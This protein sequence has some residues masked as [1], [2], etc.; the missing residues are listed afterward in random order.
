MKQYFANG[1]VHPMKGRTHTQA[2]RAKISGRITGRKLS[3]EHRRKLIA[4]L[5]GR[6]PSAATRQKLRDVKRGRN[7][8]W[9]GRTPPHAHKVW[10]NHPA[11][12]KVCV[13]STWEAAFADDLTKQGLIWHFEPQ[14]FAVNFMLNG[15]AHEGTY[16]PDFWV[17]ELGLWFEVKGR[18]LDES[19]AKF[20][21]FRAQY[22]S[23]AI[24]VVDRAYLRERGLLPTRNA[25]QRR[26]REGP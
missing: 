19:R 25:A 15:K 13:R 2:S 4:H 6:V 10:V 11:G 8:P 18:W 3:E 26:L 21:A 14:V 22:P 5:T 12:G 9:Y 17:P 1:G 7:A 23:E 20:D 16:R 24:I